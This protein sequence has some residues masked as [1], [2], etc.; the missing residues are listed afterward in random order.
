MSYVE[1]FARAMERAHTQMADYNIPFLDKLQAAHDAE[2][3]Q[4]SKAEYHRGFED[5]QTVRDADQWQLELQRNAVIE[6]LQAIN[7]SELH[8]SHEMLSAICKAIFEPPMGWTIG[9][10]EILR[11]RLIALMGMKPSEEPDAEFSKNGEKYQ[12]ATY[13]TLGNERH[14]VVCRLRKFEPWI[15]G[16]PTEEASKLIRCIIGREDC[17]VA[18]GNDLEEARDRLIHL[19]GGGHSRTCPKCDDDVS[20]SDQPSSTTDELRR[21]AQRYKHEWLNE[22]DGTVIFTTADGAPNIDSVNIC[23]YICSIADRI[24]AKRDELREKLLELADG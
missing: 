7:P 16:K 20:E 9:A 11:D 5:G 22:E 2:M 24:D 17:H 3:R 1:S 14:K 21:F 23:E 15:G 4:C 13:D 6:R 18:C 8:G 19:L 12:F 10:G